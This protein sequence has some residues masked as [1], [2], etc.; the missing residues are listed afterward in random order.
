MKMKKIIVILCFVFCISALWANYNALIKVN[1]GYTISGSV[2]TPIQF[3]AQTLLL[4]GSSIVSYRWDFNNDKTVDLITTSPDAQWKYNSSGSY[5]ARVLV[6]T[7][8]GD[9]SED[10]VKV[11]INAT[12]EAQNTVWEYKPSTG[13]LKSG[14]DGDGICNNYYF[15]FSTKFD[16]GDANEMFFNDLSGLYGSLKNNC[17]VPASNIFSYYNV[18]YVRGSTSDKGFLNGGATF[19]DF[20]NGLAALNEKIDADDHVF[21]WMEQHGNGYSL[22]EHHNHRY[23]Y[24]LAAEMSVTNSQNSFYDYLEKDFKLRWNCNVNVENNDSKYD[25]LIVGLDQWIVVHYEDNKGVNYYRYKYVSHYTDLK[26]SNGQVVSDNDEFIEKIIDYAVSDANKNGRIDSGEEIDFTQWADPDALIQNYNTVPNN[27]P[28]SQKYIIFDKNLDNT[29]ELSFTNV[30]IS[31][32]NTAILEIHASDTDNDG[33]FEYIDLNADGDLNDWISIEEKYD[34]IDGEY[35]KSAIAAEINKLYASNQMFVLFACHSGGIIEAMSKENRRIITSSQAYR[36]STSDKSW[37]YLSHNIAAYL[38]YMESYDAN[39]DKLVTTVEAFNSA[40]SGNLYEG[41]YP[42][43]N[44]NG[45][46]RSYSRNE[47]STSGLPFCLGNSTTLLSTVNNTTLPLTMDLYGR[48]YPTQYHSGIID[49]QNIHVSY[50][51]RNCQLDYCKAV[52]FTG[53][54]NFTNS[55]NVIFNSAC[56]NCK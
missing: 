2:Q 23:Q 47:L 52:T 51:A 1:I 15:L 13:T 18:G 40:S 16:F 14:K 53:T 5:T 26:L 24:G 50:N 28:R 35:T 8:F 11:T 39:Y 43:Y 37:G 4:D 30:D 21:I 33:V 48:F 46:V 6:E 22:D 29:L 12:N 45:D 20:K 9:F 32:V 41:E 10:V 42:Q 44:E 27:I 49:L 17:N 36:T 31:S 3:H 38:P 56:L 25:G 7:D 54:V 55:V 34:F 19:D